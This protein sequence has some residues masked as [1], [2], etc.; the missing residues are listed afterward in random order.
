MK[1]VALRSFSLLTFPIGFKDSVADV[2]P[3][4]N[5][6]NEIHTKCGG[7]QGSPVSR[8]QV[9]AD[10]NTIPADTHVR[11]RNA[12]VSHNWKFSKK[13]RIFMLTSDGCRLVIWI[14]V[15]Q[16]TS[17][18]VGLLK[19]TCSCLCGISGTGDQTAGTTACLNSETSCHV[20]FC[21]C[22]QDTL[23]IKTGISFLL[24]LCSLRGKKQ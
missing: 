1:A 14:R 24:P 8:F 12:C 20:H 11:S 21:S 9:V 6:S 15:R 13:N 16:I 19:Q 18:F 4:T 22:C 3:G 23:R 2:Y 5:S 10:A 17:A 7:L